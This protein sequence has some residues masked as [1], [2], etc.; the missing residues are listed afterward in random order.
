MAFLS[1]PAGQVIKP[2]SWQNVLDLD[3]IM[4]EQNWNLCGLEEQFAKIAEAMDVPLVQPYVELAEHENM[5]R[6]YFGLVG[7]HLTASGHQEFGVQ[8][9]PLISLLVEFL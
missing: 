2:V 1:V 8:V 5:P 4:K 7:G 9:F 6:F 3:P